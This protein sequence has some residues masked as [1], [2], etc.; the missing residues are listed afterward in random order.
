MQN[1]PKGVGL[2]KMDE[3]EFEKWLF[4]VVL[5]TRQKWAKQRQQYFESV[6]R[7]RKNARNQPYMAKVQAAPRRREWFGLFLRGMT[8][9]AIAEKYGYCQGA[10]Q[11]QIKKA[12]DRILWAL[13]NL[14]AQTPEEQILCSGLTFDFDHEKITIRDGDSMQGR[15]YWIERLPPKLRERIVGHA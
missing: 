7:F 12:E 2:G 6:E 1:E 4:D 15:S 8:Q 14:D 5:A 10:V 9:R 13:G 3:R 11:Q